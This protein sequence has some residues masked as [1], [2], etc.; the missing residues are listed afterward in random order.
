MR[1]V[2]S[3]SEYAQVS[4][5]PVSPIDCKWLVCSP[6]PYSSED[7]PSSPSL[8]PHGGQNFI[9]VLVREREDKLKE[10]GE[11]DPSG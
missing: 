6:S 9:P 7:G 5:Y 8:S 2:N 3:A 11:Q 4:A 10:E 1:N